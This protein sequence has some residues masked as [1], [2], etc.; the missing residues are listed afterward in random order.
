ME[1]FV[2]E[3]VAEESIESMSNGP[4]NAAWRDDLAEAAALVLADDGR[5]DRYDF[6]GPTAWTMSDLATE[7]GLQQG[8]SVPFR[9]LS[10]PAFLRQAAAEGMPDFLRQIRSTSR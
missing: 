2:D 1:N 3:L 6:T 8:R 7:I 5:R 4:I 9:T 10:E